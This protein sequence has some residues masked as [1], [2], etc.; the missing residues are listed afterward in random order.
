ME[1]GGPSSSSSRLCLSLTADI[2]SGTVRSRNS[3]CYRRNCCLACLS[4]R[5]LRLLIWLLLL[6]LQWLLL[7]LLIS[8]LLWLLLP[9]SLRRHSR[10]RSRTKRMRSG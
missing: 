9:C 5:W 8:L 2:L 1:S 6:L 4:T 7:L 3:S 10:C